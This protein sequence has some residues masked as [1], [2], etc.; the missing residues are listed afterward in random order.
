MK[1]LRIR[2]LRA[3]ALMLGL[4]PATLLALSITAY[5][6][7]SQ[8][9]NLSSSFNDRG[10]SLAKEAAAIS[11]YGLFTQDRKILER[12]LKP[13]FFQY[14]VHSIRVLN[15]EQEVLAFLSE[16]EDDARLETNPST[17]VFSEPVKYELETMDISDYPE[18]LKR[19]TGPITSQSMGSVVISLSTENLT[20]KRQQ[21]LEN[22][23]FILIIGLLLTAVFALT[24]S[25]S[26][27]NPITRLTAAVNRM[28]QGDFSVEV[29][30]LSSGELKGL[31]EAFNELSVQLKESHASMQQQI[32]QA[33]ADLTETMEALEIHNVELDL[34]KKRALQASKAKTQ[35][36]ANMSHEIRTPMN[37]VIGFADLLLGSG[38]N[39][40]QQDLV[41][42]ISKS[43]RNLL[44]II[45]EIL[46][47]SK[48]E[49]GKLEPEIAPFDTYECF[50]EPV[51]LLSPL[52]HEKGL[53]LVLMIYSDVPH[54]LVGDETRIRQILMNL[55]SNAVKF[56]HSGEVVVRVM[57]EEEMENDCVLAFSVS[58]T[59]IG[60]DKKS[61]ANLF[62]TFKQADSSTSRMYGGT[63]LGLSICKKLA[64]SMNGSIDF[65]SKLGE[66]S[67]FHVKLKVKKAGYLE[68]M[69]QSLPILRKRCLLLVQHNL[70][71]LSLTHQLQ[72]LGITVEKKSPETDAPAAGGDYDFIAI[73]L[74]R[75]EIEHYLEDDTPL[76]A[77][78]NINKPA[79]ILLSTSD[80]KL[81][82][83]FRLSPNTRVVSKPLSDDN[84]RAVLIEMFETKGNNHRLRDIPF[85]TPK[86]DKPLTGTKIL[87]VDDNVINLKLINLLLK[88]NG[89]TVVEARD[90]LQAIHLTTDEK[91]DLILMDVH[92]P[93][94]KG[95]DACRQIRMNDNFNQH[96]PIVGL[97][98]DAVPK[99]RHEVIAAGMNDY[100]LKP[101]EK[102]QLWNAI[103]PLLNIQTTELSPPE[104]P[105]SQFDPV[106]ALPIRDRQQLLK[107]T[108]GDQAVADAMFTKFLHDLPKEFQEI[109]RLREETRWGEL[110]DVVHRLH[111]ATLICGVPA[112]DA[113]IKQL[114]T[115]SGQKN[116]VLTDEL[117]NQFEKDVQY[118]L[119][120]DSSPD[121]TLKPG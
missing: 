112:L 51:I 6:I 76:L 15:A 12:S 99:T 110:W 104:E 94:I 34:A 93:L 39:P 118:L 96:T 66:G 70:A 10:R 117:I 61:Q 9:E 21:I 56:T 7:N 20:T 48:L 84:L 86:Q 58:D 107:A 78:L 25:E 26:V 38:L 4:L 40:Q 116:P 102:L 31:E 91:F 27:I 69:N 50:E 8:L 3:R 108:G 32:D 35:F 114:E 52:A 54:K 87:V 83:H 46:D 57:L 98:A 88:D 106:G 53:E 105:A 49:Y 67:S 79:L 23:L 5:L 74:V 73:G 13:V 85:D 2:T 14:D 37:G 113:T 47:Y 71:R 33:T 17:V 45:N 120:K 22:S 119:D 19:I 24:L 44:D 100:L 111:G 30:E 95:T 90:G 97:T 68:L 29:P 72:R 28:K 55:L 80:R 42:T 101:V 60:I 109:K 115:A 82:E 63:G 62:D 36:L 81:I 43:A 121:N 59:G 18:Q 64:Q 103:L 65:I 41:K 16:N 77:W 75:D 92:M 89:A 11:V 1:F